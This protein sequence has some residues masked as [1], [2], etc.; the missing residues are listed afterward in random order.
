MKVLPDIFSQIEFIY[1]T[2]FDRVPQYCLLEFQNINCAKSVCYPL[3]NNRI[4]CVVYAV[5][6]QMFHL[7]MFY[8][9]R[10][11]L[12]QDMMFI[13]LRIFFP[14]LFYFHARNN[15]NKFLQRL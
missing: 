6:Q 14:D 11:R 4:V 9:L 15:F 8:K 12:K 13:F 10:I 2:E 1:V 3:S 7:Y 5:R